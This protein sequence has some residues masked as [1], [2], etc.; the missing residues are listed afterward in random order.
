MGDAFAFCSSLTIADDAGVPDLSNVTDMVGMFEEASAF[1]GD[2][3]NWNTSSVTDMSYMFASA[4]AFNGDLSNW[5]TSSVTDMS[6]MFSLASAFNGD[7]SNWNTS[8]VTNMRSMFFTASAFN[9]DLGNWN[10]SSVTSM[11]AMFLR[12]SAFNGDLSKWNTSSVTNMRSM[13]LRASAF[14][15]DLSNWNTSSVT[16]MSSMF[17][18]ASTFNGDLS[19]WDVSK[20]TDMNFMFANSSFNGDISNWDVRNV[21]D[22]RFMFFEAAAFNQDLIKWDISSVTTMRSMFQEA[23]SMS[24]EN[25]DALLIG[26]STLDRE[27]GETQIPSG[28]RFFAPAKYSCRGKAGRDALTSDPHSWTIAGDELIPIRTDAAALQA[29]K[30]QCEVTANDL[31]APTA[32]SSC[33]VGAGETVTATHDVSSFPITESTIVTWTYTHNSKSIVQTQQVTIDD[34][35]APTVTGTLDAITAW[36]SLAEAE[37]N[38]AAPAAGSDTCPGEVT[39]THDVTADAFPITADRTITWTHTDAAGNTATQMQQVTITD[40]PPATPGEN[41]PLSAADDTKEAV[42]F[43]NPSGRYVEVQSPVESPIRIL[44]LG[45]ELVLESTTNT[46]IDAAFLHSGLYLIQLPDGHLLKFVKK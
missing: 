46:R 41:K 26:W 44:S 38:A 32:K 33:T 20:V 17:Q 18:G 30:A 14:N 23:S 27:A 40:C 16:N 10:T 29:V 15:G 43:P 8:S 36:C 9:G 7:L 12:A 37:V 21:T 13:F 22:M 6:N 31:T 39:V 25:Y 4:S 1:N 5:N 3:S 35:E 34:T 24:S 28:I 45:G 19:K 42:V 2:L 11:L